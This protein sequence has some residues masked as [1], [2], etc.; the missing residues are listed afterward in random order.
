MFAGL[1]EKSGVNVFES[2]Q[3]LVFFCNISMNF[4]EVFIIC[5]ISFENKSNL[6]AHIF[7]NKAALAELHRR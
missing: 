5:V 1:G 4:M 3:K 2:F 7:S 6:N